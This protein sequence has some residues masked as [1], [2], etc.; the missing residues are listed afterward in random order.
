MAAIAGNN[1]GLGGSPG[2]DSGAVLTSYGSGKQVDGKDVFNIDIAFKG[3]WT[4]ALQQA[5]I[6][7]V[8]ATLTDDGAMNG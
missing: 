3:A 1:G 6:G 5:L 7:A 2:L 8:G 4:A